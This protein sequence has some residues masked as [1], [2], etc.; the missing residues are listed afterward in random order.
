MI[1]HAD[2][3]SAPSLRRH[4]DPRC[5]IADPEPPGNQI[6][7]E[8]EKVNRKEEIEIDALI[9]KKIKAIILEFVSIEQIPHSGKITA[10][11]KSQKTVIVLLPPVWV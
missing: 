6:V 10:V 7:H 3:L 8:H 11:I 9:V 5:Q 1:S 4:D 2:P